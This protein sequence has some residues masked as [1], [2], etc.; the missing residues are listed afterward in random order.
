MGPRRRVNEP[1]PRFEGYTPSSEQATA[2]ARA[3]KR[4]DTK[5]ELALRCAVSALGLRYR[6]HHADLPGKPDLVFAKARVVVFV[7][8][9]FW[10]GREWRKRRGKLAAGSNAP[11]WIAKIGANMKRDHCKTRELRLAG[12]WVV[13]MWE[14][15]VLR[16]PRAAALMLR[17]AITTYSR[18]ATSSAAPVRSTRSVLA[19][20]GS[21]SPS[22]TEDELPPSERLSRA[23]ARAAAA[24]R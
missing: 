10:H 11:Y 6:L 24:L 3:I 21:L 23:R 9:D 14:T 20:A 16:D 13:R 18:C 22:T 5:A 2:T 7:D 17:E 1:A 15:D 12:W 19:R 4:K 8:G